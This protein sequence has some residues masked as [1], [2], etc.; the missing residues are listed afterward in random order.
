MS[1]DAILGE[2]GGLL[3]FRSVYGR[4]GNVEV[5]I[6][7]NRSRCVSPTFEGEVL[8]VSIAFF[9][10]VWLGLWGS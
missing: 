3:K 6:S 7:F 10:R 2:L 5:R 4:M 1:H 8:R 9:S